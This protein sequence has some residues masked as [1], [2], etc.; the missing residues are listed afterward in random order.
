MSVGWPANMPSP[1][2][3]AIVVLSAGKSGIPV[4]TQGALWGGS[5]GFLCREGL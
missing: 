2:S 3:D 1:V 4:G 5:A